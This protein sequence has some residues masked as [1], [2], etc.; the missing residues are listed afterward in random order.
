ML[1]HRVIPVLL[2][3]SSQLV[4]GKGYH[5]WRTTGLALQAARLHAAR[6]VDELIVLDIDATPLGLEV[7]TLIVRQLAE[8]CFMPLAVGGGIKTVDQAAKL[9]RSG[10]DKVVIGSAFNYD[11]YLVTQLANRFGSQSVVVSVDVNE[12]GLVWTNCGKSPTG[13]DPVE[14]AQAAEAAGAGEIMLNS[15]PLD[16]T[17]EG[18]DTNLIARVVNAVSIPVIACGGAGSYADMSCALS[19]GAHAV[20]AGA[21]F[22]FTDATPRGAVEWLAGA[23]HNVRIEHH[24]D[25]RHHPSAN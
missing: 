22:Q 11:P 15:I 7:E 10:A 9:F 17:L 2:R 8:S 19:A 13:R 20:A 4:K 3:R 16:G 18:Y 21:L 5:S 14:Y 24:D 1:K 6:S 12:D 25:S 23:G